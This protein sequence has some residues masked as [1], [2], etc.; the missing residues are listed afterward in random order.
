ML[1]GLKT[2]QKKNYLYPWALSCSDLFWTF[3]REK[4]KKHIT[5]IFCFWW[6]T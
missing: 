5:E 4:A 3:C 1:L 2:N 6:L